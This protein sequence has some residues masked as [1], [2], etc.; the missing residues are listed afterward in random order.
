[1]SAPGSLSAQIGEYER[2]IADHRSGT[3]DTSVLHAIERFAPP[4]VNWSMETGC[5]KTTI[6]LS[7]L[8]AHHH[9]FAFDDRAEERSSIRYYEDC[10][11]F[12]RECTTE[13]LGATQLTLPVYQFTEP[14]DLALLDG[15]HGYPFPELEYYYVY[16]KLRPGAL[17][18]I[19]DIHIPTIHRLHTFLAEEKMFDLV[20]I[21]RTTSFFVRTS[22]PTFFPLGDG[23]EHQAFN[24]AR[25]PAYPPPA[26]VPPQPDPRVAQ[27]HQRVAELE[28]QLAHWQH[29]AEERRLK[30]RL[31]R[32]LGDWPFLR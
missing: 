27:L 2:S 26:A 12:K 21:E 9:V 1:M 16:P 6:L 20:H 18:I 4:T 29:V 32:R 10:P 23:W 30:R 3:V 13:V 11:L 24:K 28:D 19:D 7:N 22:A 25:F 8:S 15:P 5:G 31:A 17:L 14:I